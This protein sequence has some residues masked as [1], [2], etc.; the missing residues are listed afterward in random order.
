MNMT[1]TISEFYRIFHI[2]EYKGGGEPLDVYPC[3]NDDFLLCVQGVSVEDFAKYLSK[4]EASDYELCAKDEVDENVFYSF[5]SEKYFLRLSYSPR[6][7]ALRL[8]CGEKKSDIKRKPARTDASVS[9]AVSQLQ[10]KLGM[11]YCITLSDGTFL[12]I[13]GGLNDTED[14]DRLYKYLCDNTPSGNKPLVRAWFMTHTHPDHTRLAVSFMERY[15]KEVDVLEAVYNFPDYNQITVHRESA[16]GNARNAA[17]FSDTVKR[18]YPEAIHTLC[19]TGEIIEYP[20]V[21]VTTLITHEDVYPIPINSSNHTSSVWRFDF[22][23]GKSFMCLADMSTETCELMVRTYSAEY[24]K[25]D[26][27]QVVHHGLLGGHIDL[28][29]AID[30]DI[31]LWPSPKER[32]LG[33]WVD[34]RRVAVGKPTVQF[35]IGEG[36]CDYNT[37][38]RDDSIK[39]REH[40]HAGETVVLPV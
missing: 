4:V 18:C 38:L 19:R 12:M 33:I 10:L 31:C 9:P 3:A 40:F 34:P 13:D 15:C 8:I 21:R 32:F 29:R 23:S 7:S 26:I 28:Y 27:M 5:D 36:G 22:E 14:E 2:P 24:L 25:A 37:W 30:P 39:K 16:E 11:C 17:Q 35:C 6:I 1:I 20:G